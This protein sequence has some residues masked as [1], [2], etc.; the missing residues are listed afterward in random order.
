MVSALLLTLLIPHLL[1][2]LLLRSY[3]PLIIPIQ[4]MLEYDNGS[5]LSDAKVS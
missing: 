2:L 3:T 4:Q 1:L 5:R